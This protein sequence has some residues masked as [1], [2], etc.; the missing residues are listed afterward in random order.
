MDAKL[1]IPRVVPGQATAKRLVEWIQVHGGSVSSNIEVGNLDLLAQQK[2]VG[3]ALSSSA[4]PRRDNGNWGV[5]ATK[6]IQA[7][8]ILISV[9]FELCLSAYSRPPARGAPGSM[10][11]NLKDQAD[12]FYQGM[13]MV[14]AWL[15]PQTTSTWQV[16]LGARLL[17]ER[18]AD[19][20][21]YK[22]YIDALPSE[23]P[24]HPL[25]YSPE[26]VTSM[27][28]APFAHRLGKIASLLHKTSKEFAPPKEGAPASA[29]SASTRAGLVAYNGYELHAHDFAWA[30]CAVSSRAFA[31]P[32]AHKPFTNS[33]SSED[34]SGCKTLNPL[35]DMMNHSFQPNCKTAFRRVAQRSASLLPRADG[36]DTPAFEVIVRALRDIKT[37]EELNINYFQTA[38][39][40]SLQSTS[41]STSSSSGPSTSATSATSATPDALSST[42]NPSIPASSSN[43]SSILASFASALEVAVAATNIQSDE[44]INVEHASTTPSTTTITSTTVT[45]TSSSSSSSSSPATSP[46]SS[47]TQSQSFVPSSDCNN[48]DMLL[49]FGFVP[50]FNLADTFVL[51]GS[52]SNLAQ[53]LVVANEL[54]DLFNLDLRSLIVPDSTDVEVPSKPRTPAR[55]L[56]RVPVLEDHDAEQAMLIEMLR[57]RSTK[58]FT[59][60]WLGPS[61]EYLAFLRAAAAGAHF[62][63][64]ETSLTATEDEEREVTKQR[65]ALSY[66][67]TMAIVDARIAATVAARLSRTH[68]QEQQQASN[69]VDVLPAATALTSSPSTT[70]PPK[71]SVQELVGLATAS[72][73]IE[74]W[75]GDVI[76][77]ENELG[78]M[79]VLYAN[80]CLSGA[81]LPTSLT[82]DNKDIADLAKQG[83]RAEVTARRFAASKKHLIV[84]ALRA[85]A[86][87]LGALGLKNPLHRSIL[88]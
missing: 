50:V 76:S 16:K 29:M 83:K 30:T 77:E 52:Q 26:T 39:P 42:S 41:S 87:P 72:E 80:L 6:D 85:V 32:V 17:A 63:P 9:P 8:D 11:A 3:T 60:G 70:P 55:R 59:I 57:S 22:P 78:A 33:A 66:E 65:A 75:G 38:G 45:A 27:Q 23:F 49:N 28:Y 40:S 36:K 47:F 56:S 62:Y 51:D 4:P 14:L 68:E 54:P 71:K 82:K 19:N 20:S 35:I 69:G 5:R 86:Q 81:S 7:G 46:S 34:L 44:H 43:S 74:A 21:F 1:S 73:V 64:Q 84:H 13:A 37:G 31:A 10:F 61:T 79:Q 12:I 15:S 48:D 25:F 53:V 18:A 88:P 58:P 67:R 2:Q 24:T